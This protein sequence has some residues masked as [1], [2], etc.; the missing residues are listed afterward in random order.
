MKT[1]TLTIWRLHLVLQRNVPRRYEALGWN[2]EAALLWGPCEV[3]LQAF[4]IR[5]RA[6]WL[7]GQAEIDDSEGCRPC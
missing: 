2:G 4:G 3:M 6:S 1:K 5:L 7:A